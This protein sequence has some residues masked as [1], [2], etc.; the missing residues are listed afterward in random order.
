MNEVYKVKETATG[1]AKLIPK[2][3]QFNPPRNYDVEY[4]S[5]YLDH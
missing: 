5:K 4:G 2:D 3:D 1:A